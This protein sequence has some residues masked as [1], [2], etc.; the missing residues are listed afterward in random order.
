MSNKLSTVFCFF[1]LIVMMD[2]SLTLA[3]SDQLQK[4]TNHYLEDGNIVSWLEFGEEQLAYLSTDELQL[5]LNH[6]FARKGYIFRDKQ[7]AAYFQQFTWYRPLLANVE[8][9]L[10]ATD[11]NNL[12]LIKIFIKTKAINQSSLAGL[13]ARTW[14]RG[15]WQAGT[16]TVAARY[17]DRFSFDPTDDSFAFLG[18]QMENDIQ[19]KKLDF[20][21]RFSILTSQKI[22]FEIITKEVLVKFS[23]PGHK[24][25]ISG[26]TTHR[27]GLKIQTR[28]LTKDEGYE[29][30]TF[31]VSDFTHYIN[32]D[33]LERYFMR[34]GG[35]IYWRISLAVCENE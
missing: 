19:K 2:H 21:G 29:Y 23:G 27:T 25:P 11:K 3:Q 4:L 24:D 34:I 13:D 1:I 6:V 28:H 30:Q 16:A 18:N 31:E 15:C 8:H 14:V 12:D 33:G 32:Q 10:T 20:S 26:K 5:L 17:S 7:L 9:L 35:D 22:E